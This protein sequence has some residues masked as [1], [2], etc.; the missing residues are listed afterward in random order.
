MDNASSSGSSQRSTKKKYA[1]HAREYRC[2]ACDY[3]CSR[4]F[5]WD[6]HCSTRKHHRQ[7]SGYTQAPLV[8]ACG[9]PYQSR[10][11]LWRHKKKCGVALAGCD[12]AEVDAVSGG[13]EA[14]EL[15]SQVAGLKDMIRQLVKG[16][17]QDAELKEKM[18]EQM[19][20][21]LDCI[22]EIVPRIGNNNSNHYNVNV[23]LNQ[24]CS[25]AINMTEFI[26]SMEVQARD[27]QYTGSNGLAA[28]VSNVLVNSLRRLDTHRRP[29]HCMNPGQPVLYVKDNDTWNSDQG[30]DRIRL[31][32]NDVAEK[33]RRAIAAWTRHNPG[34][35][36][37]EQ[38]KEEY[39]QL[40]QSV[41]KGIPEGDQSSIIR[42]IAKETAVPANQ[43]TEWVPT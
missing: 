25:E 27:L 21:Q 43:L 5:L 9:K 7:Q 34:W 42:T 6:Q 40:V 28:G 33:Q 29:I 18:A 22:R 35:E 8:C 17:G 24:H 16:M 20:G 31:A 10:A 30:P 1:K 11:G 39:L 36:E 32:I 3:V 4:K 23:F 12:A 13:G 41:M 38:G 2:E 15:A 19:K 37:S 26:A 14:A